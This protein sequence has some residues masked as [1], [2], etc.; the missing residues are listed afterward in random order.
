MRVAITFTPNVAALPYVAKVTSTLFRLH[1]IPMEAA[2]RANWF[3][4]AFAVWTVSMITFAD[5][6]LLCID[7][8]LSFAVAVVMIVEAFVFGRAGHEVPGGL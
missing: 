8:F 7:T 4:M 2:F 6:A 5:V 3:A 1:T